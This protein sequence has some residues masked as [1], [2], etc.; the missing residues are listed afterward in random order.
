MILRFSCLIDSASFFRLAILCC[1][2]RLLCISRRSSLGVIPLRSP[3]SFFEGL[4]DFNSFRNLTPVPPTV[5]DA[6]LC[7]LLWGPWG[8]VLVAEAGLGGLMCRVA[9]MGLLSPKTLDLRRESLVSGASCCKISCSGITTRFS[10]WVAMV[11]DSG[12]WY[13]PSATSRLG[14]RVGCSSISTRAVV[15]MPST[16]RTL[17]QLT[18]SSVLCR[19]LSSVVM[20][21]STPPFSTMRSRLL[22]SL[23][24]LRSS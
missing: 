2:K 20:I 5:A 6:G 17:Q 14:S 23:L 16:V 3:S 18:R 24:S 11:A 9:E 19:N 10:R 8:S 12:C 1:N 4:E 21:T 15:F 13:S 7:L 22:A